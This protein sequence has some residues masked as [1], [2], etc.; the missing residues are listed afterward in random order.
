MSSPSTSFSVR[1]SAWSRQ[2]CC[3]IT[4]TATFRRSTLSYRAL[5]ARVYHHEDCRTAKRQRTDTSDQFVRAGNEG[6]RVVAADGVR[7][8]CKRR[9]RRDHPARESRGLRADNLAAA[10]AGGCERETYGHDRA[11]RARFDAYF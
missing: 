9:R 10:H 3:P 7:L 6:S 8:L 2:S 4:P 11:G 1:W 5:Y